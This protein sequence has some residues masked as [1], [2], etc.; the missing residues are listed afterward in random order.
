MLL[1][2]CLHTHLCV[3]FILPFSCPERCAVPGWRRRKTTKTRTWKRTSGTRRTGVVSSVGRWV[4]SGGTVPSTATSNRGPPEP[5]VSTIPTYDLHVQRGFVYDLK[6]SS[7]AD[8]Y[9]AKINLPVVILPQLLTWHALVWAPSP[10]LFPTRLQTGLE[11]PGS[12]LNVWV[13]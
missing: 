7:H 12:P 4:T 5:Q 11:G 10:S 13:Q 9:R 1:C 6:R 8:R 3:R 2:V